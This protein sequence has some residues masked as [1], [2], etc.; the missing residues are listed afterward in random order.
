MKKFKLF[1][2]Q[3]LLL[4]ISLIMISGCNNNEPGTKT[5]QVSGIEF[6]PNCYMQDSKMVGIDVDIAS[7]A[8][9]DAGIDFNMN[10]SDSWDKAYN[11]TLKG[12]NRAL[13]T[14]G[15][16]EDRKDLFK[17]AG[18]ISQGMYGVFGKGASNPKYPIS[19][20]E[21][22]QL[23]QI[24]VVR[25]WLETTTLENMGFT[26]LVYYD[27]YTAAINAFMNNEIKYISSDFYHLLKSMPSGYYLANVCAITRYKTV[28][29]YIAFSKDVDDA[30]V[31]KCQASIEKMIQNQTTYSI[32]QRYLQTMP[33]D[34]IP[35]TI[36][37]FTEVDPP[38]NYYTGLAAD[39]KIIGSSVDIINEIQ[40]RNGYVNK[41]NM[42]TWTDAY[43]T[44]LY[45]PNSAVFTTSR[46]AERE[47][48]FQWVGPID[49]F[50]SSF[51]TLTSSGIKITS[52]EDAKALKSIATPKDWFTYD[53]LVK[54][55]FKNIVATAITSQDAFNQLINGEVDALLLN[56]PGVIWLLKNSGKP[57]DFISK[58]YE[59]MNLNGYIAF[60]LS[61]PKKT[62][63]Q[64]Q[65][66][67]DAM[68]ADGTFKNIWEQWFPGV[69]MPK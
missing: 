33:S 36:Q 4:G 17:W 31:S 27:T 51:Y 32:V 49:S 28:Y 1:F 59:A 47:K 63:D 50:S 69:E 55:G 21:A 56:D 44:A 20:D 64:W 57:E 6:I 62:V 38:Y 22:K 16:S 53:Y 54:N 13:I 46:T 9:Q 41:I 19:I 8:L 65:T 18:P 45:L 68:K 42:S 26:N 61:T 66:N 14:T 24:A 10:L 23:E 5:I 52:I 12:P 2:C 30:V 7:Q 48:L 43:S 67:L 34:Y 40:K 25:G 37:L 39:R 58:Q 3:L 29:Y 35:G 15:Y 60:S 11:A